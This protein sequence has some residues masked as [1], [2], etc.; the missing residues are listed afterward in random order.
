VGTVDEQIRGA[1][2]AISSN[3]A[4]LSQD[5]AL[6]AQNILSQLRN[7]VEGVVVRL[8]A[9]S[10]DV[11]FQYTSVGP[12]LAY[13]GANGKLNFLKRFHKLLQISASHY[14]VGG[15]PSE[16]LVLKYYDYL[17]RVRDLARTQLTLDILANLEDFPV[18]LDPSLQEYHQKIADRIVAA[19]SLPPSQAPKARYYIHAVRPF[20]TGRHVYYE[21]TFYNAVNRVSKFDR[22]I[23]FTDIDITDKYAANLTLESDSIQVL[24]QTMPIT[25]IREWE[26]SIRPCEFD[27]F[28]R[29]LG[30]SIKVSSGSS[31]Y[32]N[33]MQYLTTTSSS[34]LDIVDMGDV[35]YTQV[36]T[37]AT[38]RSRQPQIFPVLDLAHQMIQADVA[39]S[40]VLRYLMLRM[41]NQIIKRQYTPAACGVLSNLRLEY[42]CKPFDSI[43]SARRCM[44]TTPGSL[45]SPRAWTQAGARTSSWHDA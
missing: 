37:W 8:Q 23:G 42:G 2:G 40:N 39:G 20:Y 38:Q 14:T 10:G 13:V 12:A 28:G 43:R 34:L 1:A 26:V 15:D 5:R 36:K 18:D 7:L 44:G 41:N 6:L 17:H 16:R 25:I 3:I 29:I 9:G 19:R 31:E 22:I 4:T 32:R 30:Q 11:E 27:N 35:Q 45:T 24:G 33:L 21:V